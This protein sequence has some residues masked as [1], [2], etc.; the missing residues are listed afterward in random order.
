LD[1]LAVTQKI[2]AQGGVNSNTRIVAMT[3]NVL[4][5]QVARFRSVGMD[6]HIL[7]PID[8]DE[9][10][11]TVEDWKTVSH[12]AATQSSGSA[13]CRNRDSLKLPERT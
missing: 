8:R 7:K 5:E 10:L 2:R 13:C 4:P 3:A 9:L 11:R 6:A 1:G 12:D